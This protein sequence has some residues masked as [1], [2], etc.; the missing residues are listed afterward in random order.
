MLRRSA[1]SGIPVKRKSAGYPIWQHVEYFP[2]RCAEVVAQS[3]AEFAFAQKEKLCVLCG[4]PGATLREILYV[5]ISYRK[6]V[7]LKRFHHRGFLTPLF[8]FASAA[9]KWYCPANQ[10]PFA[11]DLRR[12]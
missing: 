5:P 6:S 2:Q 4:K 1:R 12:G 10:A 7:N 9:C 8:L 11:R 3:C